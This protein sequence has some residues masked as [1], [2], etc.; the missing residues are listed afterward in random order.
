MMNSHCMMSSCMNCKQDSEGW[1]GK[2]LPGWAA[3]RFQMET[4]E[5]SATV[6]HCQFN[7]SPCHQSSVQKVPP[8]VLVVSIHCPPRYRSQ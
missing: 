4:F 7:D 1:G 3:D 2:E 8:G 6:R 5:A